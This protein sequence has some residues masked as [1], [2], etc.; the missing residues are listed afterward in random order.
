MK[1]EIEAEK[2]DSTSVFSIYLRVPTAVRENLKR[3]HSEPCK[4]TE[5]VI[6]FV[7]VKT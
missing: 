2:E 7:N 6:F 3:V 5:E 1:I 4:R